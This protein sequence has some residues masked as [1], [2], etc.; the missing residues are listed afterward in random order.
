MRRL[1]LLVVAWFAMAADCEF[2]EP[3]DE[4]V[5]YMCT[6]H[7]DD[8]NVDCQ[9]LQTVFADADPTLQD[10]CQID[11]AEQEQQDFDNGDE[12]PVVR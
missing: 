10:Q 12:C 1:V 5:D 2:A 6:C 4:Y 11:L 7:A 3:C 8:P 9:E